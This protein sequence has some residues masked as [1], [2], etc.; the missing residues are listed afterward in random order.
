MVEVVCIAS[1][2]VDLIAHIGAPL[3][4]GQ[5]A[6]ASHLE[7]QPGGKGS[8]AAIAAARQGA[9][10]GLVARIGGDDF[11]QMGLD[12]W[13]REGIDT[14]FV[15]R[16]QDQING[17]ALIL[18]YA[19]GDNSIAVY[20]GAGAGLQADT[21]QA[22][23]A[24][25]AG[26]R[27]VMAS[28]EVPLAA[29]RCAFAL[30]R[31][32]GVMTLLNPAPAMP[33]PD[34]LWPLVDVL[35]PNEGELQALT[36]EADPDR[37]ARALWER[38]VGA[39]VVT[40]GDRGCALYRAGHPTLQLPG[41]AVQVADTIGAGDTFTGALAAALARDEPWPQALRYANAAAALSTRAHGAVAAMPGRQEVI[42]W[43][44]AAG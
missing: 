21:V 9:R 6:L 11:G 35:T 8:N 31:E 43:L 27:V 39:V 17:T 33:L 20:P 30:A 40:L 28:C 5:T 14:R 18:V 26:A 38:G 29:T 15:V 19:D 23:Q 1:W 44:A 32:H 3:A 7:R 42:D 16:A 4:R 10:V 24:M 37:A 22:A 36:G 2:N 34:D 12:L 25:V 13:A 41:H